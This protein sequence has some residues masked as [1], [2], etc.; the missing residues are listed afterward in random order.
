MW[1][2]PKCKESMHD[3][4]DR[5]WNCR[6][7]NPSMPEA[8]ARDTERQKTE[9]VKPRAA[10]MK[11]CP[12]CAEEILA[13]AIKC[14]YCGSA[15]PE[16]QTGRAEPGKEPK[17]AAASKTPSEVRMPK[18]AI[19]TVLILIFAVA[20]VWGFVALSKP[21]SNFISARTKTAETV[22]DKD[23]TKGVAYEEIFEYDGKGNVKKTVKTYPKT[24]EKDN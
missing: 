8:D 16:A 2:C 10:N 1:Q 15:M 23:S 18:Q 13:E 21:L 3:Y 20:M 9:T 12:Y 14:R 17:D 5:C 6:T 4:D 7:A 19:A 11:K 24:G 22:S